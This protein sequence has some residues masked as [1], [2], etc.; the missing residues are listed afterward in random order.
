MSLPTEYQ[1]RNNEQTQEPAL[2]ALPGPGTYRVVLYV[3]T[4]ED[5][6]GVALRAVMDPSV[7][8]ARVKKE[9]A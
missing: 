3:T 5:A 6:H 4:G 1:L 8:Q 2:P 9:D 7:I